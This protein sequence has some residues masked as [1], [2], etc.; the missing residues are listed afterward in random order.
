M[1]TCKVSF[2]IMCGKRSVNLTNVKQNTNI[3]Y[4]FIFFIIKYHNKSLWIKSWYAI[5][6]YIDLRQS[7]EDIQAIGTNLV[8]SEKART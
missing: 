3:S 5:N 6:E 2:F 8:E 7:V 1:Y 4:Y